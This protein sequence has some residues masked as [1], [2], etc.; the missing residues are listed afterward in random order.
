M[1]RPKA[2]EIYKHFKGN[3]YQIV[4]IAI[5]SET[6]SELVIYR[7]YAAPDEASGQQ[8]KLHD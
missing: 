4:D 7:A 3:T 8:H 1:I 6:G 2:N 5:D